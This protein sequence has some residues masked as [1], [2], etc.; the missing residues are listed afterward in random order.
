MT[1]LLEK[2]TH[3]VQSREQSVAVYEQLP[4][5]HYLEGVYNEI[6]SID[7]ITNQLRFQFIELFLKISNK[8]I[9][10]L[11]S[12]ADALAKVLERAELLLTKNKSE[13]NV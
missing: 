8:C 4:G 5:T 10:L 3:C 6:K 2:M 12:L 7:P 9:A 11:P 13:S 1:T